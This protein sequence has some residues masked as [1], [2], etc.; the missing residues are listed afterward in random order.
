[1]TQTA[2]R[3][4]PFR[5][6]NFLVEL[7]GI[8]QVS[9]IEC[10]GLGTTTEVIETREGGDNTTVRKLPGKTTYTDIV[11]KWGMTNTTELWGW[12][13]QIIEG[14]VVRKNGSIVVFDLANSSEVARWNFVNAWPSKM[15]GPAFNAKGN[16][17]AINTL[18]LSHEGITRV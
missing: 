2:Q 10:S 3:V 8:A 1:M 6:F 7:D 17:I 4:D 9:F 18:T 16:D 14:N 12:R 5:V 11:L 15:E 13:Q